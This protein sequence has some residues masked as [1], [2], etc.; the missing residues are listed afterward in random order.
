MNLL[1][2]LLNMI[3]VMIVCVCDSTILG[4]HPLG[5]PAGLT[6]QYLILNLKMFNTW[7]PLLPLIL[8][9]FVLLL[10]LKKLEYLLQ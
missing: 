7:V 10:M 4:L 5:K 2:Y 1:I 8:K 9:H 6:A 3:I